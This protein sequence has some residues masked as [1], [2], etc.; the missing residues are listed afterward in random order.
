MRMYVTA[1]EDFE[2]E[3][4]PEGRQGKCGILLE[5]TKTTKAGDYLE[6]EIY[7]VI[8]MDN[9]NRGQRRQKSREAMEKANRE[10][11]RRKLER[12]MNANFG[13]GD[14]L[15]HLTMAKPCEFSEFQRLV[16][17]YIGRLKYRAKARKAQL[18]YIYVIETT[19]EGDR[20]RHHVHMVLSAAGEWLTRDEAENLWRHGL[21]RADRCQAQEKGLAG[22]A[23][24]ITAR[25]ETQHR[26]MKRSWG[27]SK[28]LKQ[29][30]V[31]VADRKFSRAAADRIARD[32][33]GDAKAVLEK[34]YPGYRLIEE[35][36]IRWSDFLPGCYI[37]AVMK[38]K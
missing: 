36:R 25:K 21:A 11:A 9:L 24:Y 30:T 34:K 1:P 3:G 23:R 12:L 37:Y 5:R 6:C 20:E 2:R 38:K 35:P 16:R 7:P 10:R 22:F 32:V 33:E 13:P 19:G 29:P 27:A 28:N 4:R 17:N 14:L 18:K 31:T 8:A 15:L 26:L